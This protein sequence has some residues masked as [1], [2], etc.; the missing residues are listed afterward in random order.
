MAVLNLSP[1]HQH[2]LPYM[3]MQSG[4]FATTWAILQ[5]HMRARGGRPHTLAQQTTKLN[6]RLYAAASLL[7]LVSIIISDRP[8]AGR[9]YHASKFYE[10]VDILN[11]VASGGAVDLHFGFH[12]L[13]TPW[14]TFFRVLGSGGDGGSWRWF[15]ACNAAHHVLMYAYFGGWAG[16]RPVLDYT[17]VGQLVVGITVEVWE[18]FAPA[19]RGAAAQHVFAGG[20]LACYLVLS[21]REMT[22]RRKEREGGKE[23][24]G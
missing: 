6:S 21:L 10:Y 5:R 4:L 12:H 22:L 8:T 2:Y 17:G 3:V 19:R 13:T 1:Y 20:L 18:V 11:V 15:A 14:L 7:L 23:K 24:V 9:L 16:V